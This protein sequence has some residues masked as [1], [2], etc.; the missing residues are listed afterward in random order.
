MFNVFR[1]IAFDFFAGLGKYERI[2]EEAGAPG[3]YL[4]G[5]GPCLFTLSPDESKAREIL[6]R[7]R[8]QGLECYSA[9]S[10]VRTN[11]VYGP[12]GLQKQVPQ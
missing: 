3:V 6:L 4:A 7:L 5:S 9:S 11:D 1:K 12:P 8:K 10:I 2:L